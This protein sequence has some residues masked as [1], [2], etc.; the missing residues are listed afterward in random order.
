MQEGVK[1][2]GLVRQLKK[3]QGSYGPLVGLV[4]GGTGHEKAVILEGSWQ[5]NY[6]CLIAR[7]YPRGEATGQAAKTLVRR[8]G[9]RTK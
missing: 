7:V 9:K 8:E 1:V 5:T 3:R 2:E 4:V 6:S